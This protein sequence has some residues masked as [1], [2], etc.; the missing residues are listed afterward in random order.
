[1]RRRCSLLAV[2]VLICALSG[3]ASSADEQLGHGF[4]TKHVVEASSTAFEAVAHYEVL[5]F[6]TQRLGY[7][8]ERFISPSGRFALFEGMG[9]LLLFDSRSGKTEDVTDGK[10]AVPAAA[11]WQPG[12]VLVKYYENHPPS[13]IKLP[14]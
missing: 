5:Y 12:S 11:K 9:K 6:K 8:G 7:V 3:L 1:M 2:L 4:H 13:K 10:F 14:R